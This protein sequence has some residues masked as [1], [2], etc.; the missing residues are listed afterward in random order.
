[1][2]EGCLNV[3]TWMRA[4]R[5]LTRSLS[6]TP[7]RACKRFFVSE[8]FSPCRWVRLELQ[9]YIKKVTDPLHDEFERNTMGT[10]QFLREMEHS[11]DLVRIICLKFLSGNFLQRVEQVNNLIEN[12]Y[13]PRHRDPQVQGYFLSFQN[14]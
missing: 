7:S 12:G 5:Y 14:L 8:N 3:D 6:D 10:R 9:K 1:M 4:K 13:R 11:N 2:Y